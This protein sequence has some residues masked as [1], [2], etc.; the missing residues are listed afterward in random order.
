MELT[1]PD[2]PDGGS[3]PPDCTCE[4]EDVSPVLL[5]DEAPDGTVELVVTCEDPD[6][7]DGTFVHW[8]VWGVDPGIEEIGGG[9]VPPDAHLG[10]NDFGTHGY[11][12]PCPPPG[13]GA[14]HY[15]F[16]LYAL[17]EPVDLPDG[18]SAAEL[19]GEMEGKVLA[20][21]ELIGLFER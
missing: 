18:V 3:M 6:A 12:G 11:S 5:W 13:H 14:H 19:R 9:D 16:V 20:E 15:H 8:L 21:A 7:P 10:R 2:F 17:G 1:S 4:G